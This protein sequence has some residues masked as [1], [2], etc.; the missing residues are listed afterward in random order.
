MNLL[1]FIMMLAVAFIIVRIGAV[2]FELTGLERSI[3]KFQAV[4]CFTG[5][6]FTTRE[7]ELI[8]GHPQRR[9]IS[10]VLMVLGNVGIVTLVATF[11]NSIRPA[12]TFKIPFI[13]YVVSEKFSPFLNFIIIFVISFVIYRFF[14]HSKFIKKLMDKIKSMMVKREFI[15]KVSFEDL[16]ISTGGYGIS[17]IQVLDYTPVV[18]KSLRETDLRTHDIS[19]IAI[20]KEEKIIPNPSPDLKIV[21]GDRLICFGKIDLIK[22]FFGCEPKE[23]ENN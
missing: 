4:S 11:A 12:V 7:S 16:V 8:T 18:N 15:T 1:L 20:E 3:A 23:E 6:G 19:V 13:E 2:A 22:E 14:A 5:T 21:I 10:I 9:K 17:S